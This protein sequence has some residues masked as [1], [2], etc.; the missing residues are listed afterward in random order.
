MLLQA[1]SILE[2]LVRSKAD[3]KTKFANELDV[4][5]MATEVKL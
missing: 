5:L 2:N 1:V 4:N 3:Y